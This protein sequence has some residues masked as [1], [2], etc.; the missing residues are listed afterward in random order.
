M[1][2]EI[3][4]FHKLSAGDRIQLHIKKR[5]SFG[6]TIDS[7]II[8]S[9][10]YDVQQNQRWQILQWDYVDDG[11]ILHIL[12]T[13]TTP[14][15]QAGVVTPAVIIS[16]MIGLSV[17]FLSVTTYKVVD[18]VSDVTESP[19]GKAVVVAG[20]LVSVALILIVLWLWLK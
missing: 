20:S 7:Y 16:V 4:R 14:I 8:A 15:Y 3:G 12:I 6:D 18:R 9:R 1:L 11:L 5:W 2:Q 10:L 17:I 19:T 13:D